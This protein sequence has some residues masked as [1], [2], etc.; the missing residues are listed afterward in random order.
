MS[1]LN[2]GSRSRPFDRCRRTTVGMILRDF[3]D[4]PRAA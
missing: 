4:E 1:A 3:E 2:G